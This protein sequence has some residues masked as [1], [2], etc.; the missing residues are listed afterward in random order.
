MPALRGDLAC[1][2]A[3]LRTH[4]DVGGCLGAGC[5]R[6]SADMGVAVLRDPVPHCKR[7][8]E[9]GQLPALE[10]SLLR[11]A[12][13]DR[14][15]CDRSWRLE[16]AATAASVAPGT[17]SRPR[18]GHSRRGPGAI[19]AARARAVV[20]LCRASTRTPVRTL[21]CCLVAKTTEPV[22]CPS[23]F[24]ACSWTPPMAC[25]RGPCGYESQRVHPAQASNCAPAEM[26]VGDG[27][28]A[29]AAT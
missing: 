14:Y 20:Q 7:H 6:S 24:T 22:P 21:R 13:V 10:L 5:L 19:L 8:M 26:R 2:I 18:L 29:S 4:R 23:S 15:C 9:R 28:L 17:Q 25:P 16:S 3:R 1:R 11:G 27:G 12:G